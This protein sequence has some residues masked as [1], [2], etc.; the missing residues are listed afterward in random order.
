L[1]ITGLSWAKLDEGA[2]CWPY[3]EGAAQGQDRLYADG[4][5]PTA[6]GRACFSA[7]PY[8][9]VAEARDARFPFALNTGRLRDQWHGMSRTGTLGR[10]FGHTPEP[11]LDLHPQD[12]SRL[13]MVDGDLA[14]V[15]SRRG[16][17]VLPV[18]GTD[19]VAPTQA[20]VAMHWGD[21]MVLDGVNVLTSPAV[22]PQSR[23]P[24]L[25]HAAVQIARAELPW[26]LVA[27]A[28]CDD[29]QALSLR[30][31][32]RPLFD[33]F[34]YAAC[35][36]FGR[37]RSGV[38]FRGAAPEALSADLLTRI[39][40]LFGLEGKDT[41]SYADARRGQRRSVR[42][43]RRGTEQQL[44]AFLLAGDTRAEAWIAP[45]LQQSLPAQ[46]YG[47]F[48]LAPG[49]TP[50]GPAPHRSA[51]VCSCFDISESAIQQALAACPGPPEAR[52]AA[53]QATLRCGTQCGSCLPTLKKWVGLQPATA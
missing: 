26:R 10:L 4:V 23:Q 47:R 45:L 51:Q 1:D 16:K 33:S 35:V 6:T 18:R 3:P 21:E 52:L 20:F 11:T 48:L 42:L 37:D 12:V 25:K 24:E 38:L 44:E 53:L 8:K 28:W 27:L 43:S 19:S 49:A 29:G 41:L 31:A 15:R 7:A 13:R 36:P 50:P 30:T 39:A 22:C 40:T 14:S 9:A 17:L 34:G 2:Q 46:D 32:L 5:F